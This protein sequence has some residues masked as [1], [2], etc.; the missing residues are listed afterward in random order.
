MAVNTAI[1]D[2]L[3]DVILPQKG[4]QFLFYHRVSLYSDF[5]IQNSDLL[6]D[7]LIN[8]IRKHVISNTGVIVLFL[9]G[10]GH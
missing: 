3:F 2:R 1:Y 7:K 9:S 8:Q 5:R 10:D 4:R 6:F